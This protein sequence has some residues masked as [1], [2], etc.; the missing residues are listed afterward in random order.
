MPGKH[1]WQREG[2]TSTAL[3]KVRLFSCLNCNG[4]EGTKYMY[5]ETV[6]LFDQSTKEIPRGKFTRCNTCGYEQVIS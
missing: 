1:P 6:D 5:T 4:N 2:Y 3:K